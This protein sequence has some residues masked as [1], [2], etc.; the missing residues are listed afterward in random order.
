ME[1][2]R[3]CL[4]FSKPVFPREVKPNGPDNRKQ[5]RLPDHLDL[6]LEDGTVYHAPGF[7]AEEMQMGEVLD[8]LSMEKNF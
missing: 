4:L 2:Y 7:F 5:L 1:T 8:A 3:I 6:Y